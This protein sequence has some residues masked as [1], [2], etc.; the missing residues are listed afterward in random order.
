MGVYPT[1]KMEVCYKVMQDFM[2]K[3]KQH[4]I[5]EDD[6]YLSTNLGI[7]LEYL[8]LLTKPSTKEYIASRAGIH[9]IKDNGKIVT[10]RDYLNS[11]P[12]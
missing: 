7:A 8:N 10:F 3:G 4:C 2:R 1:T 11:L 12:E 6:I 9:E 5:D